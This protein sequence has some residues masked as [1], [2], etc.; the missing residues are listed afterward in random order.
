MASLPAVSAPRPRLALFV[1]HASALL[2]DHEP[3]GDGLI[4]LSFLRRLAERGHQI[5]VA[6]QDVAL[7][8]ELP[9]NLRL[10]RIAAGGE[11]SPARRLLYAARVRSLFDRLGGAR[12]F[13]LIHQFNPVDVGL[14]TFLPHR[15]PPV[16]IGPYPAPWAADLRSSRAFPPS[17]AL[18]TLRAGLQWL[19]QHRAAAVLVFVPAGRGNLRARRARARTR[20]VAPGVDLEAF[21]P[22]AGGPATTP[23][24]ILFVGRLERRK[25]VLTL[26]DAFEAIACDIPE[27]ELR[28]AGSG[29]LDEEIAERVATS[30]VRGRVTLLGQVEHRRV[31]ELLRT[32]TIFCLP[33]H[34][35]PFGMSAL[36]ALASGLPLVV[37][38]TGGLADLVPPEAG[39][40]VVPGDGGALA[41]ALH[42]LLALDASELGVKGARN[43]ALAESYSWE[44]AVDRLEDVYA[45]ALASTASVRR[46]R[47]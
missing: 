25:G 11:L 41:G 42:A 35:E 12:C 28:I 37:T 3:H 40:R 13:D 47:R 9:A 44:T 4:A 33:S 34:G 46:G 38:D 10:H 2:T 5:D 31:P 14:T 45:E 36:E 6:V 23:R 7:C 16:V 27:A 26:L 20:V 17:R 21:H 15:R 8:R 29:S 39:Y 18:L 43:R 1:A 22:A 19:Q 30:A 32:A 24:S